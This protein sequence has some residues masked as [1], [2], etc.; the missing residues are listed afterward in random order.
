M[1]S[2]PII[3]TQPEWVECYVNLKTDYPDEGGMAEM[4]A[5]RLR[6]ESWCFLTAD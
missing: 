6:Y 3:F 2:Y 4:V 1:Y 5:A